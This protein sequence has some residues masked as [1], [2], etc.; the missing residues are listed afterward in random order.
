MFINRDDLTGGG[1]EVIRFKMWNTATARNCAAKYGIKILLKN[2]L[3]NVKY[4]HC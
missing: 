1:P 2:L 4:M 3:Q